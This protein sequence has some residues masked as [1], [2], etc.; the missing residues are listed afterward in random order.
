[1]KLSPTWKPLPSPRR[2]PWLMTD[3][4]CEITATEVKSPARPI[5]E[6]NMIHAR[7]PSSSAKPRVPSKKLM[8]VPSHCISK[9][10]N[11]S[12]VTELVRGTDVS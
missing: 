1:M 7:R 12:P 4:E 3:S 6:P 8:F 5:L 2:M 9:W 10:P 11:S